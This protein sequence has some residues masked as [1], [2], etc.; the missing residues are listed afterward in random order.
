MRYDVGRVGEGELI[1]ASH[2]ILDSSM[3]RAVAVRDRKEGIFMV[4]P[5]HS[6][7]HANLATQRGE[8]L[9][10]TCYSNLL[11]AARS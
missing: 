8:R 1:G 4:G 7:L 10:V 6:V 2:V 9:V 3:R 11:K 5:Y